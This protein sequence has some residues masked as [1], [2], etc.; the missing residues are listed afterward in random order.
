MT[1]LPI[2]HKE[3][4]EKLEA[5]AYVDLFQIHTRSGGILYLRKNSDSTWQG[6][7]YTGIPLTLED[8]SRNATEQR[9]RPKLTLPNFNG[10]FSPF[11]RDKELDRA[12]VKRYRVLKPHIISNTNIFQ[13]TAWLAWMSQGVNNNVIQLELRAPSDG[14]RFFLPARRYMPPEFSFVSL[15]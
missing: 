10:I 1:E 2:S 4:N 13:L 15:G 3:E 8:Y 6:E 14:Q 11:I 7:T 5:E 12:L 9:S